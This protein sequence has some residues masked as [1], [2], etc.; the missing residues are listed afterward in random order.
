MNFAPQGANYDCSQNSFA[1]TY[2]VKVPR[3]G[4]SWIATPEWF[5]IPVRNI[6]TYTEL[7][8]RSENK[9][10]Y[11]VRN[12]CTPLGFVANKDIKLLGSRQKIPQELHYTPLL[13]PLIV[14]LG[15][16]CRAICL[17]YHRTSIGCVGAEWKARLSVIKMFIGYCMLGREIES[18]MFIGIRP[19]LHT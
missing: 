13:I 15:F 14:N 9:W 2:L 3:E 16:L 17:G 7:A 10:S 5:P 12:M 6:S 19:T 18:W 1:R 4:E 8:T 11:F